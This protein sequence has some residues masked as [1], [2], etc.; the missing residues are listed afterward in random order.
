MILVDTVIIVTFWLLGVVIVRL[1]LK[2]RTARKAWKRLLEGT[3][4]KGH[5]D[6]ADAVM[7]SSCNSGH[8][9][10]QGCVRQR[11][12]KEEFDKRLSQF[13]VCSCGIPKKHG[14]AHS[15]TCEYF[16][17]YN[18]TV[19]IEQI[20]ARTIDASQITA[21]P[22]DALAGT[23]V[24]DKIAAGSVFRP[25][26][27]EHDY[28]MKTAAPNIFPTEDAVTYEQKRAK[29]R[30]LDEASGTPIAYVVKGMSELPWKAAHGTL[31]LVNGVPMRYVSNKVLGG[32][33]WE[34]PSLR[35]PLWTKQVSNVV[36]F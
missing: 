10:C 15:T 29:L 24:E 11:Q 17:S 25:G 30:Q 22:L 31:A 5:S 3:Q 4:C 34:H 13:D 7:C 6:L 26:S 18:P 36:P 19:P 9:K 32:N 23:V 1:K 12:R 33:G 21:A 35:S 20:E 27:A 14:R 2:E 16:L 28:V 8:C